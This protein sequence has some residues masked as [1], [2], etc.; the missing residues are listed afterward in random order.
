MISLLLKIF[1]VI[2]A[3]KTIYSLLCKLFKRRK[4]E[5]STEKDSN[6]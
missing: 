5:G 2:K 4:D 1:N 6:L 3:F